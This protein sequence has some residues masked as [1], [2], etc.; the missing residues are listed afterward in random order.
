VRKR[1]WIFVALILICV[2]VLTWFNA[3]GRPPVPKF[4]KKLGGQV[5]EWESWLHPYQTRSGDHVYQTVVVYRVDAP[6]EQVIRSLADEVGAKNLSIRGNQVIRYD[7][8]VPNYQP[9]FRSVTITYGSTAGKRLTHISIR[10]NPRPIS[11][12]DRAITKVWPGWFDIRH[13]KKRDTM[14]WL[15]VGFKLGPKLNP[16]HLK[17]QFPEIQFK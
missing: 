10:S 1:K 9:E 8:A 11:A 7:P 3:P 14:S 6:V 15:P 4:L 17:Q 5:V 2:G 13:S 16:V 12:V